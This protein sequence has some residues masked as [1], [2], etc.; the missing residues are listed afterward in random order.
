MPPRRRLNLF[1]FPPE[2]NALFSMLIL[3]SIMLALFSGNLI[4]FYSGFGNPLDWVGIRSP[5]FELAAVFLAVACLSGLVAL[6]T[7]CLACLFFLRYPS[8]IRQRR[9]LQRL[10]E[11]DHQIQEH[12]SRLALQ[13]GVEPPI[14][15]MP[16]HG[17][18]GSDA[19]AFG[20]GKRQTIALDGGFRVLRKTK[21]EIFNAL[22]RHELAHFANADVSK[23]YFS[24]ALW[25]SI[26]WLLVLPFLFGIAAVVAQG[27]FYG[28]RNREQLNLAIAAIPGVIGL[29]LQWGFVL[30]IVS[31]IWARLL[32]TREFYADWRAALWGS[33]N[34]LQEILQEQIEKLKVP[35][36]AFPCGSSIPMPGN[37]WMCW[38]I[39]TFFSN[40]LL[41]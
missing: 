23:S 7:L 2:T 5:R 11:K 41:Q 17:L 29:F 39:L 19:Q 37:D 14:I 27:L 36:H 30:I 10:T 28:I 21:P 13:A 35:G 16:L 26:R 31:T 20:V 34:G 38:N 33:Q 1:A 3:A 25:R 24:D 22:L 15:E 9:K 40:Y 32:R 6:G 18:K 8:Q 4:R 12:A